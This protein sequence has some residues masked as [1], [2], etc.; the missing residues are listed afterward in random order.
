M[1][2]NRTTSERD[3]PSRGTVEIG[4]HAR[5]MAVVTMRGEH[6]LS[7]QPVLAHALELAAAHSNVVVDLSACSFIDSTVI[8]E[9]INTSGTV[10]A[11]GEQ[12]VL[13]I[14]PEQTQ[15]ARI[16]QLTGL[17]HIFALHESTEAAFAMLDRA[18]ADDEAAS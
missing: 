2:V 11:K 10:R 9:F 14:P 7:T 17:S 15:I 3:D 1:S 6:D 4:H 5:G 18:K 8:R 16:A 12:V 13:V